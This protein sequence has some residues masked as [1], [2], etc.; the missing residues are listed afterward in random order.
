MKPIEWTLSETFQFPAS[1]GRVT[2]AD[3]VKVTAG[4]DDKQ[5]EDAVRLSGIYHIAANVTFGEGA[6]NAENTAEDAILIDDVELEGAKGYFEYAVPLQVDLPAADGVGVT[7][8]VVD[9]SASATDSG[10]LLVMWTVQASAREEAVPAVAAETAAVEAAEQIISA[11]ESN[12]ATAAD[13]Q[14]A[15]VTSAAAAADSA[16]AD[17]DS[18]SS[19]VAIAMTVTE[20][21][22]HHEMLAFIQDLDD[23]VSVTPYVLNNVA[24]E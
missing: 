5:T 9:A 10:E 6:A 15:E 21:S 13:E 23:D 12:T 18:D 8:K 4:Y 14:A 3:S 11:A 1:A 19:S 22:G 7:A 24:V 2:E 16:E 17:L 20:D